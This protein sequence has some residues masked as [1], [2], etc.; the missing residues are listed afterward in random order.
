MTRI[1]ID[2]ETRSTADLRKVGVFVY[3]ADPTTDVWCACWAVDDGPVEVWLPG[4]PC[5]AAIVAGA[6]GEAVFVAHNAGFERTLWAGVLEPRHGWP[7]VPALERW[8]CTAARA[9]AMALPRSLDGAAEALG[10]PVRKDEEGG[11]LMLRMARPRSV[12]PDGTAVWWT[13]KAR[14]DRLIAYCR[15][16]VEVEHALD[17]ALR[18][19]GAHEREIWLLDQRINERGIAVDLGFVARAGE[20]VEQAKVAAGRELRRITEG[21][22][23]SCTARPQLVAWLAKQ[24]VPVDSIDKAAIVGLL[25]RE[26]LDDRVLEALVL[27]AET[28]KTSTAKLPTLAKRTSRDGRLRGTI[29]YHGASTGRWVSVGFQ[30]QNLPRSAL[31]QK[32]IEWAIAEIKKGATAETVGAM[33]GTPLGVL[34]DC[35]RGCLV[36]G[37]G[38]ILIS[39]DFNA[40]ESRVLAFLAGEQWVLNAYSAGADLYC[41]SASAIYGRTID[42]KVDKEERQLGKVGVLS[43]IAKGELVLTDRGLV[44]IEKVSLAHKLWDGEE[45]VGHNGVVAKGAKEVLYHDG[46]RATA[47]HLVWVEG[48]AEPIPFGVAAASGERLLRSGFGRKPIRVGDDHLSGEA[49]PPAARAQG[50]RSDAV[51]LVWE[52][53]VAG[54]VRFGDRGAPRL[55]GL[56]ATPPI[57]SVAVAPGLSY[58]RALYQRRPPLLEALRG[59]WDRISIL[60]GAGSRAVDSGKSGLGAGKRDRPRQQ[61]RSLRTGQPALLHS[62]AEHAERGDGGPDRRRPRLGAYGESLQFPIYPQLS[63]ARKEQGGAARTGKTY[64]GC[65]ETQLAERR[66]TIVETFDILDAG[67][68]HRFTVAGR[69]VHNCGFGGGKGAIQRMGRNYGLDL[70]D[71]TAEGVKTAWREANPA[72]VRLW[73]ALTRAAMSAVAVPGAVETVGRLRMRVKGGVLWLVLPSGRPLAYHRPRIEDAEMPWGEMRP[74][75]TAMGVNGYT[76]RWERYV[77]NHLILAENAT[78]AVARDLLADAMLRVEAAGYPVVGSVHDEIISE[79]PEGFGSLA[80]FESLMAIVP[81]WAEGC[82]IAASGWTGTRYRK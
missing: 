43:C 14:L 32:D 24:G 72:T 9:A 41:L 28:A 42:P 82:P 80:E 69:L 40:I 6:L 52:R 7:A 34:S 79:V 26:D 62:V 10:L 74:V 2:L 5:P 8:D 36:A 65:K 23:P 78:Q 13:D 59:A 1:H 47:D 27:W 30:T 21:A 3:A 12:E 67:P 58:T 38:K 73:G 70:S 46:L 31:K 35:I 33:L 20:V 57:A 44:P 63:S 15:R 22:V 75:V 55:S 50:V 18:P 29:V 81:I 66:R 25:G 11:R 76:R 77:L 49:V 37:P 61:R 53:I 45:W 56:L 19:L 17:K 48:P 68:H 54:V 71:E 16:D 4:E 64:G 60:F 51:L 39:A